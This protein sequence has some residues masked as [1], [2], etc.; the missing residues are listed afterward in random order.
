MRSPML[1]FRYLPLFS[2]Y[3]RRYFEGR[4]YPALWDYWAVAW[5]RDASGNVVK[6]TII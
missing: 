2:R 4:G 3:Y 1:S 5:Y 6:D